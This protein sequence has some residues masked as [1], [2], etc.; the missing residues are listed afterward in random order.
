MN[1]RPESGEPNRPSL[2]CAFPPSRELPRYARLA[3]ELGYERLWL[4]D[5]P[6]LYGDIWMAMVRVAEATNAIGLGTG[7]AIPSLRHVMVSASAIS[8]IEELAP[9]RL[10]VAFGTGFTARQSMG[11]S[12]MRWA[13]LA[14]YVTKLRALLN[15]Q[16][17]EVDGAQCQMIQSPGFGSP[18]PIN[19][20]LLVAPMG[21]K[22]FGV[23][24]EVA[25]GVVLATEPATPID[26]RWP[27]RALLVT[28]TILQPGEDS[29]SLR[30]RNALGPAFTT[31]YH[32]VWQWG[33]EAVD[34]MPGGAEWRARIEAER[35]GPERHLAV[36]EGH[37][38]TVTDRDAPTLDAAGPGLLDTGWTSVARGFRDR[39]D[40]AGSLGIT[41]VIVTPSGPAIEYELESFAAAQN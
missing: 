28:G 35:S 16:V 26:G 8:T 14:T 39:M 27:I 9:S 17:V 38:V 23:A 2:A 24:Q 29:T 36:H 3:E 22:G 18:R 1:E 32:A 12:P 20:P 13:D 4:Y 25:D 40:H 41:Q 11:Q 10:V 33:G 6:A 19:V 37:L 15:G 21:P 7:V 30:V 31:S 5:S 34:Q